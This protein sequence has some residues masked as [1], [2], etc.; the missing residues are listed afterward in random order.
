MHPKVETRPAA[1][2]A[3]LGMG[4]VQQTMHFL[5]M[6]GA[7]QI[8]IHV[9]A[10]ATNAAFRADSLDKVARV[11]CASL[12]VRILSCEAAKQQRWAALKGSNQGSL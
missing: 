5:F 6:Q 3:A 9:S 8:P 2:V 11:P 7:F 10:P 1:T 12:L 4:S